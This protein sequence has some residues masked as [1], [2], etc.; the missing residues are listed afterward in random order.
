MTNR[1]LSHALGRRIESSDR[2]AVDGIIGQVQA[3]EYPM[4]DLIAA[5]VTSDL[6]QQR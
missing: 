5:I 3:D 6:F 1:L 2:A 4:A